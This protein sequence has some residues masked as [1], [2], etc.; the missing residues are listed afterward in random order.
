MFLLSFIVTQSLRR[1]KQEHRDN[2]AKRRPALAENLKKITDFSMEMK[3]EIRSW[4]KNWG[5]F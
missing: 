1:Q 5:I 3:W 4:G 2:I